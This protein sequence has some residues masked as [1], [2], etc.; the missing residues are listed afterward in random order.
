MVNNNNSMKKQINGI[1]LFG[2]LITQM[3]A[4]VWWASATNSAVAENSREV[5][6]LEITVQK[7]LD[8]L[9]KDVKFVRENEKQIAILLTQ[10]ENIALQ[11]TNLKIQNNELYTLLQQI[12]IMLEGMK[13]NNSNTVN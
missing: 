6:R 3:I 13:S 9:L 2:F 11:T 12:L 8:E 1:T 7:R 4:V 10:Q 5:V